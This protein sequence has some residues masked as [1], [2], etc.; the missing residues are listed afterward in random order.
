[1]VISYKKDTYRSFYTKSDPIVACMVDSLSIKPGMK[2]LEPCGG[3]GVFVEALIGKGIDMHIDVY[4]IDPEAIE[5]LGNKFRGAKQVSIFREDVLTSSQLT[6]YAGLGGIYDRVIANP[7]YGGWQDYEKR[8]EL[9][10][11]YDNLYVKETYALFLYR[12]LQLLKNDG[13]LVFIIPDTYLN[14]HRHTKLR[15][16]I[17]TNSKLLDIKLFP[18]SFFPG[19]SFGYSNLSILTLQRQPREATCLSNQIRVTSGFQGVSDLNH[20]TGKQRVYLYTQHDILN[21]KDHAL[22]VSED[23]I[24]RLINS[25]TLCIGDIADC[26]TGFYSG[27]DKQY[28][29]TN[30]MTERNSRKYQLV[31]KDLICSAPW[32]VENILDGIDDPKHFIPIVKGGSTRYYKPDTWYMDW[33]VQAVTIYKTDKR[34]RFQNAGY[35]FQS[36]VGIPMVSASCITA[37]LIE[38]KLFDQSIVGVFPY[39]PN[40][41]LY[42]LAFFNS[43]TCNKLIRTINP[44][45]N[46]SANYIKKIPFIVPP[47][48]LL[49]QMQ[50]LASKMVN[51]LKQGITANQGIES[52]IN[53]LIRDVYE[54]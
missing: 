1:M 47:N 5:V 37:A 20:C 28:L 10:R 49:K 27:N 14:L 19:V 46:N 21:N 35:Y 12:C 48:E 22:F 23:K 50:H 25:S 3:D 52:E 53:R 16:F 8:D 24:S 18:S 33:S 17:L 6:F 4:E 40:F 51:N 29:Y 9:K 44:S 26:V 42:L 11:L 34:A 31:K 15:K 45:A 38:N 2:I 7:P 30:S 54:F 41:T 43:P 39:D 13:V 36:G 32:S